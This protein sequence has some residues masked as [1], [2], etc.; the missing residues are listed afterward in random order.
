MRRVNKKTFLLVA[1][2]SCGIFGQ[3]LGAQQNSTE[4]IS[5]NR[6]EIIGLVDNCPSQKTFKVTRADGRYFDVS[7][8]TSLIKESCLVRA[9]EFYKWCK[10]IRPIQARFFQNN[11]L[12]DERGFNPDLKK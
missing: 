11:T 10:S 7:K 9:E 5:P 4:I 3:A 6:C 1:I 12:I 2:T 8:D